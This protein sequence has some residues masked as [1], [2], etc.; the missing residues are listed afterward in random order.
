MASARSPSDAFPNY[1][2]IVSPASSGS[3][4]G[5]TAF[6]VAPAS[7]GGGAG[8]RKPAGTTSTLPS[9]SVSRT[10]SWTWNPSLRNEPGK[11]GA[12]SA[13]TGTY[14]ANPYAFALKNRNRHLD[15][16]AI[17]PV[18]AACL[19]RQRET[20]LGADAEHL[21]VRLRQ[22]R[23]QADAVLE[24]HAVLETDVGLHDRRLAR[25]RASPMR[26]FGPGR[27]R[28]SRRRPRGSH[29][30]CRWAGIRRAESPQHAWPTC[31]GTRK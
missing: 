17:K 11:A 29:S 4:T 18:S 26:R 7:R 3:T 30:R 14:G 8:P 28:R 27:R 20:L 25:M 16:H 19:P 10:A 22:Q 24:I 9:R 21:V 12:P 13:N 2:R 31:R 6:A 15:D 5:L 1:R 23:Y